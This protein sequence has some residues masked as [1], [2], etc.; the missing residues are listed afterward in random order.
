M[1][2]GSKTRRRYTQSVDGVER[3]T[4]RV[5]ARLSKYLISECERVA[6]SEGESLATWLRH[7]LTDGITAALARDDED[8]KALGN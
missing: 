4:V 8:A 2:A 5:E 1:K 6:A 7:C 3:C